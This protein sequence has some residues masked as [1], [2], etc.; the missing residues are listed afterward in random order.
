MPHTYLCHIVNL[1]TARA[2]ILTGLGLL[3]GLSHQASEPTDTTTDN[4]ELHEVVVHAR[5]GRVKMAGVQN[6]DIITASELKRAACCNLGESFTT[7]PSVDVNYSDAAT[8][9]RQ[10]RLLGLSGAYV[11]MLTENIPNFR[12]AAA[13]YGLGYVPGPWMQ[14][15]QVSKGASSVKNGF[16]SITGQINVEMKKPQT[17]P[18]VSVNMYY[19]MMNKLEANIDGNIHLDKNWSAGLLTHIENGFSSHDGNDDGFVDMPRIRQVSAM[20]RIAY[21]G[22][23]YVFQAAAKFI[24][25]RRLS[26][27]GEHH[28][29]YDTE[30]LYKIRIDTRRWE[31]FTKNAL[32]FDRDNDGNIALILSGSLHD[33]DA[34]YGIKACNIYQK[35]GYGSLMFERKWDDIHALSTGLSMNYDH[36]RYNYRLTGDASMP[37]RRS[38][39]HEF[40]NGVYAQYTL[41]LGERLSAMAGLRYDHSS[42]YGSMLTPRMHVRYNPAEGLSLHASAGRGYRSPHPLADF[43][44]LLASSRQIIISDN[45]KQESAWNFGTGGSWEFYPAGKKLGISAEYYYTTFT[46]QLMLNQDRDPHADYIYSSDS[47]S[48]SHSLQVELTF[49]PIRELTLGAAWRLNDVKAHYTSA[50]LSQKPLTSRNKGL[51]T[52]G[53]A[54]MMGLWSFD[55]SLAINGSGRMPTP[56]ELPNGAMSWAPTFRTYVQLNAQITR[57]FRHWAVYI[58]GENL[59]NYRQPNPIIGASN[60]W[61]NTFDATMVYGPLQGAMVYVGFR[62]NFTK[63]I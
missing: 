9:A 49:E 38:S 17:D 44:Y 19:D 55:M 7:N 59:T 15:I 32:M 12:G 35:E 14:S 52:A 40:V 30:H 45:L 1:S 10:I 24:D 43:G 60:P 11:Q 22:N 61:G 13:L 33:Q 21:L 8:G 37:L 4:R 20:P 57:N 31:A 42:R 46:N 25:E 58:G 23:A 56:Y 47:R 3:S 41:N 54:P 29:H 18:S 48:Y 6:G 63:Y 5:R 28:T 50:G 34:T 2:I 51:L 53:Y 26:G 62:Y 36:Y 27:Q 39:E 16:E